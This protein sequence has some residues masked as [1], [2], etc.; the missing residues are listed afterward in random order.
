MT[1]YTVIQILHL[2]VV[3]V[4]IYICMNCVYII[5]LDVLCVNILAILLYFI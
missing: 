2:G 4:Y 5:Q 3:Y 1:D